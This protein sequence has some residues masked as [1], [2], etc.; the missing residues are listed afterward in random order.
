MH[1]WAEVC[2]W[3]QSSK[4]SVFTG[5]LSRCIAVWTEE[6]LTQ[7]SVQA[8]S[9]STW[10]QKVRQLS[11]SPSLHTDRNSI[12]AISN[13]DY[14]FVLSALCTCIQEK[15]QCKWSHSSWVTGFNQGV[16]QDHMHHNFVWCIIMQV[17]LLLFSVGEG[18]FA[19]L[20]ILKSIHEKTETNCL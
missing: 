7:A 10:I 8:L 11:M 14:T 3:S 16:G 9:E 4:K 5:F 6:S 19:L 13:N 15:W 1:A 12:S 17:A 2:H 18:C 20:Y